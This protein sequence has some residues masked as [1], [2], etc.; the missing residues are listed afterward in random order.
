MI[1]KIT[2]IFLVLVSAVAFPMNF[3]QASAAMTRAEF[4]SGVIIYY[5]DA[6]VGIGKLPFADANEIGAQHLP[7]I[8]TAYHR[9]MI[10]G[11]E[12][13][14]AVY[15]RPNDAIAVH[16]ALSFL[17][18]VLA[19][20][21]GT[22]NT[23]E[24]VALLAQNDVFD[25][26]N[27]TFS[28]ADFNAIRAFVF[29]ESIEDVSPTSKRV[30]STVAGSGDRGFIDDDSEMSRFLMPQNI[31]AN[32]DDIIVF[33]TY[34]NSIRN[35]SAD[36]V[37]TI[38]GKRIGFDEQ[39]YPLGGFE[40][41]ELSDAL[42]NRPTAGVFNSRGELII[43]DS[44]NDS[45]RVISA[46]F[47]NVKNFE[48]SEKLN[49]P[50]AL[51]IDA[52]NNIF[53]A[54]TLNNRILRVNSDGDVQIIAGGEEGF[55]DGAVSVARFRAP[56]GIAVCENGIIYV[57]DTGNHRIRKIQNGFVMTVAG[58]VSEFDEDGDPMSGFADGHV[59]EARFNSPMGIALAGE[60]IIVADSANHMIRAIDGDRVT[61]LAGTGIPG[62]SD[63]EPSDAELNFPTGVFFR[64]GVL[65]ISDAK[66]NKIK[67][68]D[69]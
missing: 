16:S 25:T 39:R 12:A 49:R 7:H 13:D 1:K 10:N 27:E 23:D 24:F 67:M 57:A 28:L 20:A 68:M 62:D 59:N 37:T 32:G 21:T 54:D 46:D 65:Y 33:D 60:K 50:M 3:S 18:W 4:I 43:A 30:I 29:G 15:F 61:T 58:T 14:G 44:A 38:S 36:E 48:I 63:G 11:F 47:T 6:A 31:I 66:N 22:K 9:G 55:R 45:L 26:R 56:S 64:D 17:A 42:F 52:H 34:N 51:A 8:T 40:N 35:I 69:M 53:V 5:Y 41:G 2:A 19:D